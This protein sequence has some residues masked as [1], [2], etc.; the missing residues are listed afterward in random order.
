[1]IDRKD[2]I[3]VERKFY[4][5]TGYVNTYIFKCKGFECDELCR[6]QTQYLKKSKGLCKRC[7]QKGLPFEAKYNELKKSCKRRNIDLTISYEDFLEYTKIVNCHYCL[8]KIVWYPFTRDTK[9]HSVVSRSYNL[10]RKNNDLG[11]TKENCVVCCWK[12][13]SAKSA[14]YTY[15][16]W[17]GMTEYFRC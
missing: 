8:D 3:S 5:G 11:Y 15:D 16:E 10:D 12:C 4:P 17:Y 6:V 13:N 2:A 14:R 7:V 9:D 1:M